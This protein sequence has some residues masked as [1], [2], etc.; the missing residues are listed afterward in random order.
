MKSFSIFIIIVTFCHYNLKLD[1]FASKTYKGNYIVSKEEIWCQ[2]PRQEMLWY[3]L[4][5]AICLLFCLYVCMY[6]FSII[7]TLFNSKFSNFAIWFLKCFVNIIFLKLEEIMEKRKEVGR[8]AYKLKGE[9]F[10]NNYCC[11]KLT[12]CLLCLFVCLTVSP[13]DPY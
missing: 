6:A 1:S 8:Y 3:C 2:S 11:Q 10:M 4:C 7:V 13:T 5:S 9:K 12:D